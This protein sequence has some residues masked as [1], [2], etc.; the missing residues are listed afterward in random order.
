MSKNNHRKLWHRQHDRPLWRARDLAKTMPMD[1]EHA[2]SAILA[3]WDQNVAYELGR[4]I[5]VLQQAYPRFVVHRFVRQFLENFLA[6]GDVSPD[7]VARVFPSEAAAKLCTTFTNAGEI[8]RTE[9]GLY[10]VTADQ[11]YAGELKKA[12]MHAGRITSSR[13]AQD[14]LNNQIINTD[15][16]SKQA[17]KEKIALHAEA[18]PEDV[19]LFPSG[20]AA[21]FMAYAIA[22]SRMPEGRAVQ[23][24]FPYVDMLKILQRFGRSPI[25]VDYN[26]PKDMEDFERLVLDDVFGIFC[27]TTGNPL[28]HTMDME[29]LYKYAKSKGIPLI[30]DDTIGNSY[31]CHTSNCDISITSL[32]KWFSGY[33]NV[34][35][36][37]LILRKN[38]PFYA[39]FKQALERGFDY[40]VNGQI[41]HEQYEDIFYARDAIA[42]ADN[43]QDFE[44][45]MKKINANTMAVLDDLRSRAGVKLYHPSIIDRDIYN[46]QKKAGGGYGGLFSMDLQDPRK[47]Q[48]FYD[49]AK[50][51][52]GPGFGN[53]FSSLMAYAILAH[54]DELEM[55]AQKGIPAHIVRSSIGTEQEKILLKR[56]DRGL[57]TVERRF[58]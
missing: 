40:T 55:I 34:L 27:E 39:E 21:V 50:L 3:T 42:L 33:G 26:G 52:K 4:Y 10:V 25:E 37:A 12:W 45:R 53:I 20:M 35:A 29:R 14:A 8:T 28:L 15:A 54:F 2:I 17:I 9:Q 7:T 1:D 56:F 11:A 16:G 18:D 13:L 6:Q 30:A 44:E 49:I 46:G 43:M 48:M 36:G 32:S 58:G 23:F 5:E 38:S 47:A 22:K 57:D 31:N 51:S 19:Y 41:L 24:G